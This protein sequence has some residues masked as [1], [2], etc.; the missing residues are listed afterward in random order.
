MS[1]GIFQVAI[2]AVQDGFD[3]LVLISASGLLD[4]GGEADFELHGADSVAG[5]ETKWCLCHEVEHCGRLESRG[6]MAKEVDHHSVI[7]SV[8]IE[9]QSQYFVVV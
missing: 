3:V 5:G 7:A 9:E 6:W 8:L 4:Y 1:D 2:Q